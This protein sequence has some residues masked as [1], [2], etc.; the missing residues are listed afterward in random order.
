MASRAR[1]TVTISELSHR[2]LLCTADDVMVAG[3]SIALK[4]EAKRECWAKIEE[5]RGQ[6]F[7]G[8]GGM[9]IQEGRDHSSHKI[10]I[11]YRPD[12]PVSA[13]AWIYE[14]RLTSEPRWYK[15]LEG[16]DAGERGRYQVLRC[17]LV[18]MSDI[19]VAPIGTDALPNDGTIGAGAGTPSA[20]VEQPLAIDPLSGSALL[21]PLVQEVDL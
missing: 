17:R 3:Q 8:D 4:R 6:R 2:I 16:S 14:A 10:T 11:R 18:Q 19:I 9:A 15:V 13:L 21:A 7:Y 12:M 5:H 1:R 20:V